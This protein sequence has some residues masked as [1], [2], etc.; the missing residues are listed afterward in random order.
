MRANVQVYDTLLDNVV[1]C[2]PDTYLHKTLHWLHINSHKERKS[3]ELPDGDSLESWEI[4]NESTFFLPLHFDRGYET[5][6]LE[7]NNSCQLMWSQTTSPHPQISE[8]NEQE[9]HKLQEQRFTSFNCSTSLGDNNNKR[10]SRLA[11]ICR[12]HDEAFNLGHLGVQG[13]GV[14][15][16]SSHG[17]ARRLLKA[18]DCC[19]FSRLLLYNYMRR[20]S[21]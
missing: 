21:S 18:G 7:H 5:P 3:R 9:S 4:P 12:R 2:D 14:H 1:V 10:F 11:A 17:C 13:V 16:R 20:T 19:T 6:T 8:F 15:G